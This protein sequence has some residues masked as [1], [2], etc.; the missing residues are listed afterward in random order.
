MWTWRD[1][2]ANGQL[3]DARQNCTINLFSRNYEQAFTFQ[4][5]NAWPTAV[6][7]KVLKTMDSEDDLPEKY[8]LLEITT[9]IHEGVQL[10]GHDTIN[11]LP[12]D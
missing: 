11:L 3:H 8:S 1:L 5:Y 10:E 7:I 12:T 9:I 2:V 4:V 6:E